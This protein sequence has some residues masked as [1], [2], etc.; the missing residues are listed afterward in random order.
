MIRKCKK[1]PIVHECLQFTG[2]NYK[3][4]A[5]FIGKENYNNTLNYPNIITLEGTM[6]VEK[7]SWILK[8]VEDEFW[9]VKE[10]IFNNTYNLID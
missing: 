5:E 4:C 3:E 2:D 10:S 6:R 9:A 1:K 8:G 7:G